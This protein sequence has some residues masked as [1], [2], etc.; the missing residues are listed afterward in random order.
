MDTPEQV[1][2]KV[3]KL[4]ESNPKYKLEAYAF[5]LS[6]LH[7]TMSKISPPRH[8]SGREFCEGIRGYAIDQFGPMART[9]LEHWGIKGTIDFGYL[10]FALIDIGLMRKTEEDSLDDFKDVY[11]FAVAFDSKQVFQE[12]K[13]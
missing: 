10:V 7:F 6:A 1:F 9:V 12:E 8:I 13:E 2:E 3:Q 4:I 5:I 11:D